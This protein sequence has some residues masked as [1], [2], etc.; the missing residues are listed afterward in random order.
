MVSATGAISLPAH[1]LDQPSWVVNV[2]VTGGGVLA[3]AIGVSTFGG[4]AFLY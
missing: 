4:G 1:G 3:A 2:A